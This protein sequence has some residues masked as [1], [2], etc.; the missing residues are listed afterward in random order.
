LSDQ[1]VPIPNETAAPHDHAW[2]QTKG[3]DAASLVDG[4][5][6]CDVCGATWSM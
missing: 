5:Y 2:T 1:P 6:R 3:S 4:E